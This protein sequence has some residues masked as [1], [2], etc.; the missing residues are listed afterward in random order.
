MSNHMGHT[1][2]HILC[3]SREVY[4]FIYFPPPRNSCQQFS[5]HVFFQDSDHPSKPLAIT[6]FKQNKQSGALLDVLPTARKSLHHCPSG[7]FK[8]GAVVL[9]LSIS[10][11]YLADTVSMTVFPQKF[12]LEFNPQ[13]SSIKKCSHWEVI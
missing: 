13:C 7:V 10:R 2:I 3:P 11:W 9:H 12:M 4:L 1:Y 8:K 5:S 6:P